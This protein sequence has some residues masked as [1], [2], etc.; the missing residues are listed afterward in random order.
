MTQLPKITPSNPLPYVYP[1]SDKADYYNEA[2]DLAN[3]AIDTA[4]SCYKE[5]KRTQAHLNFV[6][7]EIEKHNRRQ[8]CMIMVLCGFMIAFN[9]ILLGQTLPK[10]F[11]TLMQRPTAETLRR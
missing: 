7:E 11:P 2:L 6:I 4:T 9:L 1:S 3:D 10:D 5:T 8:S